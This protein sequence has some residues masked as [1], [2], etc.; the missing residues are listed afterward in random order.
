MVDFIISGE[1]GLTQAELASRA[2]DDKLRQL[3]ALVPLT[4]EILQA[5]I[6]TPRKNVLCMGRNYHEHAVESMR[7]FNEGP[8]P[9]DK[10]EFPIIFTK[11]I[12]TINGPF[13]NVAY[14]P[15]ITE[16]LDWE[17]ELA[18]VIGKRGK[19]I[20]R[21]EAMNH[22][23]GYMVLNDISARDI[24]K[25]HGNQYFKGKSLDGTCP[26][27]P[28]IVTA[29]DISDPDDLRVTLRVN[30][31]V[32]QDDR[33]SSMLFDVAEI[34]EQMSLGMTLE[35]GDIIATG[36]PSGIGMGRTPM[37][38]LHSGDE[39][40]CEIEAIGTIRNRIVMS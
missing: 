18:L 29:G 17:A 27:G 15:K 37:E 7:A 8:A 2:G 36:T 32:K 20:P 31:I 1:D 13:D 5:P 34:V 3:G 4:E 9:A 26:I 40:Q 39:V 19:D 38:F 33:T 28:W 24:Q 25:R 6:P 22:V 23:Y 12:T 14:D 16:Q 30:G 10:P 35:P 11:A 21:A